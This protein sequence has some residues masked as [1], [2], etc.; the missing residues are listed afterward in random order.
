MKQKRPSTPSPRGRGKTLPGKPA[1]T[2]ESPFVLTPRQLGRFRAV[3]LL[4]RNCPAALHAL[5]YVAGISRADVAK[6]TGLTRGRIGHYLNRNDPVPEDRERQLYELLRDITQGY[7]DALADDKEWYPENNPDLID[8]SLFDGDVR[9]A[10][11]IV[12]N[13]VKVCRRVLADYEA[14]QHLKAEA[15]DG[16]VA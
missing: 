9:D 3:R 11:P 6:A 4:H 7:E 12:R 15:D 10:M 8:P 1:A 16:G 5:I 2:K 14:A 13:I